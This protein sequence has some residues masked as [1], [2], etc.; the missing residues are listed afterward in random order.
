MDRSR[1]FADA[2][3]EL[4]PDDARELPLTGAQAGVW[5]AQ[6]VDPDLAIF[7]AS[8]YLEIHGVVDPELFERALRQ[9]TDETDTLHIAFLDTDDGPRQRIGVRPDWRLN[10]VDVCAEADPRRAAVEWM[11][12]DLGRPMELTEAPLFTYALF[13]IAADR[14]YW[15]HAYHHILL[16]GVG[17]GLL[18]RRVAQVYTALVEGRD[19][20]PAPFESVRTLLTEDHAYRQSPEFAA[21][22]EFWLGQYADRPDPV[23][24]SPRPLRPT[25]DFIRRSAHLPAEVHRALTEAAER[26]GVSRSRIIVAATAAFLHRMTGNPEV[27]LGLSVTGRTG[28]RSFK[29]PGMAANVLP[30]RVPVDPAMTVR[31]LLDGARSAVRGVMSHQRYRGEELRGDLGLPRDHRRYFGPQLNIVP[32]DYDVRFAGSRADAHNMSQRL[33]EDLAISVYDR[34]GDRGIRVDFDAH[35]GLYDAGELAAH[36]DRY[37]DFL[38]RMARASA[39]PGTFVGRVGL[40]G[41]EEYAA[42]APPATAPH[43]PGPTL[44]ALFEQQVRR[45]PA[46]TAVECEGT[47]LDYAELNS[48]ANRLARLLAA[49]GV[50]HEDR[51][52]LLLPRSELFAVAALGVLKAGAAYVPV[53]PGY[54]A[55]RIG[56]ILDD[57]APT[58]VVVAAGT[59]SLVAG[60]DAP[61][62]VLDAPDTTAS[63]GG[64]A[65]DDLTD[66]ERTAPLTAACPAYVI[67]TS[68]STGQP[69]GVVVT[70]AGIPNLT[71]AVVAHLGVRPGSRV[72]QFA[73]MGFDAVVL[74]LCMSLLT[75]ATLVFA[76][77][78]RLLPGHPLAEFTRQAGITHALLPPSSLAV[79]DPEGDLPPDMAFF[80]GG[81]AC[82]AEVAARWSAKHLM[83]N[84]YGPTEITVAATMSGPLTG[85]GEPPI[86]GALDG[87][88]LHVLDSG[89]APVPPGVPG[90]LYVAGTGVARGYLGRPA[91][92]GERFVANPF[93]APGERMYRTGDLVRRRP[94][95]TLEFVGRADEQVKIRGYR[96][97]PGE[98]ENALLRLP[99]VAQ[100]AVVVRP[101][102][103]GA[104]ALAAY[105]VPNDGAA[106]DPAA[107]RDGL[108]ELLPAHLVPATFTVLDAIPVTPNGKTDRKALPDPVAAEE[109]SGTAPRTA[110]ESALCALFAQVLKT[111]RVGIDDN[112]F[113]LGG[114]SLQVARLVLLI[115]SGLGVE[116]GVET[117]FDAPTVRELAARLT[118]EADTADV[119]TGPVPVP[120][121][122]DL[123]LSF[124]QRRLWFLSRLDGPSAAY[125]IPLVLTL[126]GALDGGALEAALGDLTDR[127]ESLRTL[128]RERAGVPVQHIVAAG[129]ASRPRLAL[130]DSDDDRL[131]DELTAA[132]ARPFDLAAEPPLRATLFSLAPDRHVLLLLLHHIAADAES[133]GP[134]LR[135]LTAAYTARRD[136][137]APDLAPLPVQYADYAVWQRR[138]LGDET[139]P[140]SVVARQAD[141]W[142]RA[143]A[144][145][146]DH[147]DLP[148]DRPHPAGAGAVPSGHLVL[149]LDAEPHRRIAKLARA[150]GASTFMV[151]QA[152]LAVTLSRHGAGDD[153]TVGAPVAG[154]P[155]EALADLVGFFANTVVLRT[156]TS[157]DPTFRE[158]L[159]RAREFSIAAYDHQ[160]LP[161][162]RLVETLNP[163]RSMSRHPLFQV[164]LSMDSS[165]RAL[166]SVAGLEL[167]L[168]DLPAGNAKFDL[169]LNVRE[170]LT[171][172]GAADGLLIALEYRADVFEQATAEA[173]LARYDRLLRAFAADPDTRIG[174]VP[175]LDAQEHRRLLREWN[176]TAAAE[177]L[178][179]VVARVR[180][181][182][183]EQPSAVAVTD[184][185]GD[186]TY[187]E[188][189]DHTDNLAAR[190]QESGAAP[191]SLV[192]VLADRG[193]LPVVGFLAALA[194]SAAYLPL[195]T[196]APA[197]R[198]A[199]LLTD[200]DAPLLLA[201][202]EHGDLADAIAAA[203]GRPVTV[204]RI[205]E[206]GTARPA[207][208]AAPA[209]DQLAYTIF[210]SGSTG[211]PKG[212]MVHHRGMNN[213]LLA[214]AGDLG[215]TATDTVVQNAPLTF[216]ISIWQ[217]ISPLLVGGRTLAV[218]RAVAADPDE[219][220]R[221]VVRERATVL[222]VVP[223]LLRAALEAWDEDTPV[224]ALPDLRWLVVT[225]EELPGELCR[226]W[227]ARFPAIPVV[228]AYGPTE[229]S[230]DVTHAVI[231][232]DQG[233]GRTTAPIGRAIRNTRLYVLSDELQPV[234]VGVVGDLY[235]AGVGVGRGYLGDPAKTAHTFVADPY[236]TGGGRL[237]RTGDRVRYLPDGQLEFLGRRDNQVKIR[238]R[239]IELG[240]VE[241]RLREQPGV[242]GAVATMT[243]GPGGLPRLVA[244]VVGDADP[245]AVREALARALPDHLVPSAVH[246]LDAIPLTP[247]GKTDRK[248]LVTPEEPGGPAT[249]GRA[250]RTAQEEL[251]CMLFADVLG[252]GRVGVD[253]NFFELGGHSLLATRLVSRIRSVL[254][255]EARVAAVFE[256]P[257]P[258]ALAARL[259][260]T[261]RPR[262]GLVRRDR[263]EALPLSHVQRGLWFI[264][265]LETTQGTYNIPFVVR[266][267]GELDT[268]AL[269]AAF[270]A[271]VARHESLRTVFPEVDGEPR[272]VVL[273]PA[274][275]APALTVVDTVGHDPAA[276]IARAAGEGFDLVTQPPLR[277]TLLRTGEREHVLVV[278][279]H[280]I[281]GDGWSSAPLARD[282][283]EAYAAALDGETPAWAPLP[284]QYADYALWQNELLG[285][286]SDPDS[287]ISRQ[288]AH[289]KAKLANLPEELPLPFDR[290]R[291]VGTG[292]PGGRVPFLLTA[293]THR[294]L[295]RLARERGATPFMV[296]HT[297]LT[298]LLS[299]LGAGT[300]IPVG[301][302]VHGRGEEA[303]DPLVGYFINSLVLRV[304]SAGDP[305]F[306]ELLER[307][308]QAD[309]AAFAHQDLPFERLV[310]AL[311]PRRV[312]NRH[313]LFQ[314]KLLLQNLTRAD[315]TLPELA[316]EALDH[317][318]DMA[319]ADLQFSL[320]E[321][322]DGHGEPA[323]VEG[324]VGY[325]A[326][327]FDRSTVESFASRLVRLL[328]AALADPG[329]RLGA[330]DV[331]DPAERHELLVTRN[332]TAHQVP[333][334]TLA[335][336]FQ[337][338]V[339][340]APDAPVVVDGPLRLTYAQLDARANRLARLLAER[341]AGTETLI[342]LALPRSADAVAAMLAVGKA[343]AAY[344]PLDADQPGTRLAT[345]LADA[346][347]ALLVTSTGTLAGTPALAEADIPLLLLDTDDTVAALSGRPADPPRVNGRA[348]DAAYVIYTSGSTGRPKG[349]VVE[350]RSL[351][352]YALHCVARY[353]GLAGRTLLHSPLSFDLG[354]TALYGTLLAGG[355]LYVAD[356]DEQLDVQGGLTFAKVTPSHLPILETLPEVFAPTAQLVVGGEALR[357]DQLTAWRSAHPE[358]DVVNHYG[359][360][361]TTVGCLDH[362]IPAGTPLADGSVVVGGPLWNTRVYVLDGGLGVVPFGVVGEL[363]VGGV[364]V[365]R[366]Y[367]GRPGVTAG[368]FVAD[369]F[370]GVGERLYRT[371]DL[372]RW[373]VS[374]LEFVGRVDGQVKVRGFRVELG[375]VESALRGVVGV[376]GAVA[377][378]VVGPD[379]GG[380]LVGFVTGGVDPVVVRGVVAG[381]LPGYAV[382]SVVVGLAEL[383]LTPNGKVDRGALPVPV[384]SGGVGRGPRSAGEEILCGLFAEVLGVGVVGPEDDFFAL[385]GHS[386]LATRLV[387]RVRGVF[388]VEVPVRAVFEAPSVAGLVGWVES[389]V[390]SGRAGVVVRERPETVPLS[391]AQRRLWFINRLEGPSATYNV[392][393]VLRLTGEIDRSAL[394]AALK[395]LVTRHE[396]LRTVYPEHDGVPCQRILDPT[397]GAPELEESQVAP[398]EL[399]AAVEETVLHGFDL[400]TRPPLRAGLLTT[401]TDTAALVLVMHHI[402]GDGWSHTP[403]LRDLST[404]YAARRAGEAPQWQPL[405]VQYADYTLWQ[406]EILGDD[407]DPESELNRQ[408]AY[409]S[410]V[411]AG[412]PEELEYRTDRPRPEMATHRGDSVPL[413]LGP[414]EHAAIV[415]LARA[416]GVSVFMVLQAALA[417]LLTRMGAGTDIPLGAPTA[418]R[419]DSALDDLVGFFVNTL[420]LRTDTSGDPTFREL[421][422]RVRES[423]LAAYAHQDVPF[424]RLVEEINPARSLAR[425]PLFQV[426]LI[427][428]NTAEPDVDLPG[429][430]ARVEGAEAPVARFDMSFSLWERYGDDGGAQGIQG[431]IRYAVDLFDRS[432]TAALAARFQ[433]L[434]TAAAHDP[435]LTVDALPVLDEE[436]GR[437]LLVARNDTAHAFPDGSLPELFR[438]QAAR[439]PRAVAFEDGATTL[440]YQ[441]LDERSDR[442]AA[443]LAAHGVGTE[444]R[445]ALLLGSRAEHVVAVLAVA[446][447]GGVYVPLDRRSPQGRLRHILDGTR[448]VAVVADRTTLADVPD[449]PAAIVRADEPAAS[450]AQESGLRGPGPRTPVHPDQLAYV[451]HTSGSTGVPK[452]VAVS[453]RSVVD[454]VH[455]RWWGHGADD[456]VLMHLPVSFDAST[457]ELWGPLLRGAR[458]VAFD[459]EATDIEGLART[460][461][462]HR[463]TAGLFGEGLFRLLAENHPECFAGLR[464]IYV[465]GDAVSATAVRK[466]LAHAG[467]ARLTNTYGPTECTQCAV[468]HALTAEDVARNS[469]P[470]GRPLDNTRVYVLDDRLRPVPPGVTGELHIAGTGLARGYAEQPG[471][472]AERFVADPFG[473]AGSRMYRTG[474]RVWWR[475]DGVLEFA[476]RT[477]TQVKIRGFRIEPGE[478]E[479]AVATCPGVSQAVVVA[480][481]ARPGDRRL[482]AYTVAEPD[483]FDEAALTRQV[484]AALP[485]YM[486]PAAF[487]RLDALPLSRN[488]KLDKSA[489]PAPEFT[490]GAGRAPSGARERVLCEL[491]AELLGLPEVGVDDNF[492]AVGGD[493]IVS[494]QLVARARQAGLLITPRDV[495]QY[496]SVAALAPAA[497]DVAAARTPADDGVG[498]VP[499]TPIMA[500]LRERGG[501][502][503]GFNQSLLLRVP[504][505]PDRAGLVRA[506]QAVLDRHDMLRAVLSR[507]DDGRWTLETRP[508][509]AVRAE[510]CVRRVALP[511]GGE[512]VDWART[513]A[514]HGEAARRELAPDTGVMTRVVWFDAG[515]DRE[516]RLLVIAHHL[517][518][519]GVS[520]RV[521]APDLM[522]VWH[523]R[524]AGS[525]AELAPVGTSFR[526]WSHRLAEQALTPQV[527]DEL[528]FWRAVGATADLLLG[529]RPLDPA[530]DTVGTTR[531]VTAELPAE[532][533][534]P[535]L[536]TVP[537]VLRAAVDE[538][539]LS[540]FALA[541][542]R[543]RADGGSAAYPQ[544]PARHTAALVDLEGHGRDEA[545]EE[546]DLSR[547][548]GWFTTLYPVAVDPGVV[549]R[550]GDAAAA[551]EGLRAVKEQLRAVPR[552]GLGH[553]QLRHLDPE[554][555]GELAGTATPQIGFNYLGRVRVDAGAERWGGAPEDVRI[556]SA[557]PDMPCAHALEISAITHDTPSGPRL[558]T[559]LTWPEGLFDERRVQA[560]A[561]LWFAAL[562]SLVQH[563]ADPAAG[564]HTPSDLTLVD[565]TQDEIDELEA[566]L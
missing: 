229:C 564:G 549:W 468:H 515:P 120:R 150:T 448:A 378:V 347:P 304:D 17:A 370:G 259:T 54:P 352:N 251:L 32:F 144:G 460:M 531:R 4:T 190:I 227:S 565:L 223:S 332:D 200:A 299:R 141:F 23:A 116:C 348:H 77:G 534:A 94:D 191:E 152:A 371:G 525:A 482:V 272:Q 253:E 417:A 172:D 119:P 453:H 308:R 341:G 469:V 501:S 236:G 364:G 345:V 328:E 526:G 474:D 313:P 386:L 393:L 202:P 196:D 376:S 104:P 63:L 35:P 535:L 73:S 496:Q 287:L 214:K 107:V 471:L 377:S 309:V 461:T 85:D 170:A 112:F 156:D 307:V 177:S 40:L 49:R 219:L 441:E 547:T 331:L 282:L 444:D 295:L 271:V 428:H 305:T 502:Y 244:H 497:R 263:P 106:V 411:L 555:A 15:Y 59:A 68:G 1:S 74:E 109:S 12:R 566:E 250:P 117:V 64:Y 137:H 134:L 538:V 537:A 336:L 7:R 266:L 265:R 459:G 473:P 118:G 70:H 339:A 343:G 215:L 436:E 379:G 125:H 195:D 249:A 324:A 76:P 484:A 312:L 52:A 133:F 69:K 56:H 254:G 556:A 291:P 234:P 334:A 338:R 394:R 243:T 498:A 316:A 533:T 45:T 171:A 220:L 421:L 340:L 355:C 209:A 79:L 558:R 356:L 130:A 268:R 30:L 101:D 260:A 554:S 175:L 285:D 540:G 18:V 13:R 516:G 218:G 8:E 61:T 233:A 301:T 483:A 490:V 9:V 246:A 372:V 472:T 458:I 552:K 488:G 315:F 350:Q 563:A 518:V 91:L 424:D 43:E 71:R 269:E 335:Q 205:G 207:R 418:G 536:T 273:D 406:R 517:V 203:A 470:I 286:D 381:V 50:G 245:R 442:L 508:V 546:A 159:A 185:D 487:V 3:Q 257:T 165:R 318:P 293:G 188:L 31:A 503:A 383:P 100:A 358:A 6:R 548:V 367:V 110:R 382:P 433:R 530:R 83:V 385:G 310:A 131:Y 155:D 212:A 162:E 545:D 562:G 92:S 445:V 438:G 298:A 475:R 138:A 314:V 255:L 311:N 284:V 420:V 143:L 362:H 11:E 89:L 542:G 447:A 193:R 98:A 319:K 296:L 90:E 292:L 157:G 415:E 124:A 541:L 99:A 256:A 240:E 361:E 346:R 213:H 380:R 290:P 388:G 247:N 37:I 506:V 262:P 225:G 41:D 528:P 389:G 97:E 197:E 102:A 289:W 154:R 539:L 369:P 553:G 288:L 178:Q 169:S 280:H 216:D 142:K 241:A 357:A 279:V 58:C 464:D 333:D 237:Y 160:D 242:K 47:T 405:P 67:Y 330:L 126:D 523:D 87:T 281:A 226:R 2:E 239:R 248:A 65:A 278:V 365:G 36:Q 181:L 392:P 435:E 95:G 113:D 532:D 368:R 158:L 57:A 86:G 231:T 374:G 325:S 403:M 476:G 430:R 527:R 443:A 416:N 344:L 96:I 221:W 408:L 186:L 140:D 485:D 410:Q 136:G 391:Y 320:S 88:C 84:A 300:D 544:G 467:A 277:T 489:L 26:A 75:G 180:S 384:V 297:A 422:A 419:T 274:A 46:A 450:A 206:P 22:R 208:P 132:V 480:H 149:R 510:E 560:L 93:G 166:P 135:D 33:I 401:G 337:E 224:P 16:D 198:S 500:W 409:W 326:D 478:V 456:R 426:M 349:V 303:L 399:R 146:P 524:T 354:L 520:W 10:V 375:E 481:E 507:S 457:Y 14:W 543:W 302:S 62:L 521:L 267:T 359:P 201:G 322:F 21:D 53:D 211:R 431:Q 82:P 252:V 153:I 329:S 522:S 168:L 60:A 407:G 217:M 25:A 38:G 306:E 164:M 48:R 145:L 19:P 192:A 395:D 235:V 122:G 182:A 494:I 509:G 465:G 20:G 29:A 529:H 440:T 108:A 505:A 423:D 66:A 128:Y 387:S 34:V 495:F 264:N 114:H 123:E 400:A 111:E 105:L 148:F 80:V 434:L 27:I 139:D 72:L 261:G 390:V 514:D 402:T 432:T 351:V 121:G 511:P 173:L 81:E 550:E 412:L 427:L 275:A 276:P 189:V 479:S 24:L 451:I 294:A 151:L 163:A 519:D 176:E 161:F 317:D 437:E 5:F 321:T 103:N 486:V 184:E 342:A 232:R 466:V 115:R 477:D 504:P 210:T 452:G 258:A 439:T 512:E 28:E 42:A 174:R 44:P 187:R 513:I 327:L 499:V 222:E 323:G 425:H 404:A 561:G 492:F 51:V 413:E 414:A 446:K 454:M 462:R 396:S 463:V 551:G 78:E 449:G 366:G 127:H 147:I 455:Y 167:G 230:D 183:A 129:P 353:P 491:V 363:Y 283:S 397:E 39:E 199:E 55:R 228:N 373:T 270:A 557:D 559:T 493:S 429:L 179:D 360:T 204:L 194:A 238:G 398:D